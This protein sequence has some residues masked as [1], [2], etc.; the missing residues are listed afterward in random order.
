MFF[1]KNSREENSLTTTGD[2]RSKG[3]VLRP[4]PGSVESSPTIEDSRSKRMPLNLYTG[5]PYHS[6]TPN[7]RLPGRTVFVFQVLLSDHCSLLHSRPV[8]ACYFSLRW[9]VTILTLHHPASSPFFTRCLGPG[10]R[11]PLSPRP[12][13]PWV[14]G[15]FTVGPSTVC[16]GLFLS[17][18]SGPTC[19][20]WAPHKTTKL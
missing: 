7:V 4:S 10:K 19:K 9:L 15:R 17:L 16:C 11:M 14:P 20:R 6:L 1:D 8:S 12:R 18:P 13:S 5:L 2:L 3:T